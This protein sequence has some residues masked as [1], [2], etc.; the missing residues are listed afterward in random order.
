VADGAEQGRQAEW[1]GDAERE[2][3]EKRKRLRRTFESVAGQYQGAR[4][5]YPAALYDDLLAV[6]G[7]APGDRIL[8]I[9]CA[10]GKATLPLARRGYGVTCIELGSDLAQAARANLAGYDVSV[11]EGT[12][13]SFRPPAG[14]P[15]GLVFAA[16]AWHWIDPAVRYQRAWAALRPGGHLAF[17]AA[18]H[19]F[20]DD[21]DPIFA[22]L[23]H[24]YE[25]IGES[26]PSDAVR[27]RPGELQS[28][29]DG[30]E[31]SGLFSVVQVRQFD[32]E[33]VY[34]AEQYIALLDTFSN[35][36]A[37]A[38]WQRER[39]FSWI[40]TTLAGRPDGTLRRHWGAVLHVARRRDA[41]TRD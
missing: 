34:T 31:A 22:E 9:G 30:I 14:G 16:T 24:V 20:P 5:E 29:A 12:F 35:H 40:R 27:P 28:E 6:T 7:L 41:L 19:V 1:P 2:R 17:W 3:E 32:W 13:E 18:E 21:G 8:E 4:P 15:F 38:D 39:L 25:E 33:V 26:R 11:V 37:M 36:I 10:T 23:Q